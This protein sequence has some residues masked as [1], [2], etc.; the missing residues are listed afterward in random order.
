MRPLKLTLT[1][2]KGI[3][4]GMGLET[5]TLD[6]E[7]EA[8]EASLVAIVAPNGR[9]KT[10]ILDNLQP[11][12]LMPSK[13]GDSTS[14][15]PEAFSYF[16]HL[17][18]PGDAS[19]TLIWE[20]QGRRYR[21]LLE[22][23]LRAKTQSTTAYLQVMNAG[24]GWEP[25][26]LPDGTSSDGKA[27]T[28]DRCVEGVL[29]SPRLYFTAAFSAQGRS[30]L[31]SY[32]HGDIK[33]LMSEV[34]G[35]NTIQELGEKAADV[36][37]GLRTR[38]KGNRDTLSSLSEKQTYAADLKGHI[39]TLE[40]EAARLAKDAEQHREDAKRDAIA[41]AEME[42]EQ[43]DAEA[44]RIRREDVQKRIE[45]AKRDFDD[46]ILAIRKD[47]ADLDAQEQRSVSQIQDEIERQQRGIDRL[48]R[49]I[50][51]AEQVLNQRDSIERAESDIPRLRQSLTDT[52]ARVESAREKAA[53]A[54]SARNELHQVE[55]T[56]GELVSSGERARQ[57]KTELENRC[58]LT[59]EVPCQGTDMQG[60]C[61]LLKE[62]MEAK[63]RLPGAEEELAAKHN[64]YRQLK[65]QRD[66]L[67][68]KVESLA[69]AEKALADAQA[70]LSGV[71]AQLEA[72]ERLAARRGE[73]D[74]AQQ[75]KDLGQED[76]GQSHALLEAKRSEAESCRAEFEGRRATLND[77][78]NAALEKHD[79][80]Q[81]ALA[82]ELARIPVPGD[83]SA[84]EATRR[85]LQ[86]NENAERTA[87]ERLDAARGSIAHNKG[88]LAAMQEELSQADDLKANSE[89]LEA[90][91]ALWLNLQT[92][93][94]R[95]GILALSIDDAGPTL[96]SLTND[97]LMS[98]YGP[99]FTV[100]IDT[101]A[102]VKST[103]AQKETFDIVVL[104]ADTD[105]AKS[106][107]EMSGGERIWINEAL[108]RAIAL[109]QAQQSGHV[110]H[111]LFS[112]ES[113]GALDPEKKEQF[114]KMKRRVLELGGYEREFFI[115]HSPDVWPLADA[116]IHLGADQEVEA[117]TTA[118]AA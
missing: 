27:K 86:A 43:Q 56:L 34:L 77:R 113:D 21:S 17:V 94:G 109:Y 84:L 16:G 62:A 104:D 60:Q 99:R 117:N 50:E 45:A 98:C 55:R 18:T 42:K 93:L 78:K 44:L 14:Y 89:Y 103:G 25:V 1:G 28:Y 71:R 83:E 79:E 69:D 74:Q 87:R 80:T 61:K 116:V 37:K 51:Q 65:S 48:H 92:A 32:S 82:D 12:R 10:T 53:E 101:Q 33:A 81:K 76:L 6:L 95:D 63:S 36:V 22:W 107:R 49:Q 102:E 115:S 96:S 108:T 52:E 35:L 90:E 59:A 9:G 72:A 38:L 70:E 91:I 112:D 13:L 66:E 19:K 75:S 8:G 85:R 31:S 29:G 40:A 5:F 110:Y 100:R 15:S 68:A 88:Q 97:L 20:H 67:A 47:E 46:A 105:T 11:Y 73:L 23:K 57:H 111:T 4:A 24:G 41:V 118:D 114:V 30:Q 106:V 54:T 2:F 39:E 64:E 58:A 7:R 3:Q 26:T